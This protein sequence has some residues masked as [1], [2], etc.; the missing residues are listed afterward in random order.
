M[1]E[2]LPDHGKALAEGQGAGREAVPQVHGCACRRGPH[3]CGCGARGA[4]DRSDGRPAS[5]RRSPRGCLPDG[6][7][8]R[9]TLTA[10]PESGTI[11]APV[12]PS[13]SLISAASRFTSSQRSVWI[14]LKPAAGQHEQ[15]DRGDGG[16]RLRA[17][18]FDFVEDLARAGGTPRRSGSARASSP[19]T[20]ARSGKGF[21]RPCAGPRPLREV[22]H[23][24][25][26]LEDA[27]RLVGRVAV[28]VVQGGDV[29]P[30][31]RVD[32]HL[33]EIGD[34]EFF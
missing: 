13:G 7:E 18:S 34:H 17:V 25:D 19:C 14:S 31:D 29:F 32:R 10:A 21:R 12:L 27:V 20:S 33:A 5:C 23:L 30:V 6:E 28:L 24:S 4:E 3:G 11:R 1:T 9:G 15:A 22:E 8:R 2:Q 16:E 26:H